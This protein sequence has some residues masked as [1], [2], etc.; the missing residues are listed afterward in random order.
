MRRLGSERK[1]PRSRRRSRCSANSSR[2]R[3]RGRILS[4]GRRRGWQRRWWISPRSATTI[5]PHPRRG[6]STGRWRQR[7]TRRTKR[8]RRTQRTQRTRRKGRRCGFSPRATTLKTSTTNSSSFPSSARIP[9]A[10]VP[11]RQRRRFWRTASG[12]RATGTIRATR[13]RAPSTSS[14]PFSTPLSRTS[15]G[16]YKGKYNIL[17][18]ALLEYTDPCF[19]RRGSSVCER[20]PYCAGTLSLGGAALSYAGRAPTQHRVLKRKWV[21]TTSYA[22]DRSTLRVLQHAGSIVWSAHDLSRRPCSDTSSV[23]VHTWQP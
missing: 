13:L 3:D 14:R 12:R 6:P 19:A 8:T 23:G 5:L 1:S 10:P 21:V 15:E 18:H 20:S 17:T 9:A 7:R 22:I 2:M 11:S 16:K 4:R